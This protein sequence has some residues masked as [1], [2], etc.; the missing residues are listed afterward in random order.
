MFILIFV[1]KQSIS[2]ILDSKTQDFLNLH[3]RLGQIPSIGSLALNLGEVEPKK[4]IQYADEHAHKPSSRVKT[5]GGLS[6]LLTLLRL[7]P[8]MQSQVTAPQKEVSSSI[9]RVVASLLRNLEYWE[10]SH[11]LSHFAPQLYLSYVYKKEI[12]LIITWTENNFEA[13]EQPKEDGRIQLT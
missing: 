9:L 10:I 7:K 5:Q 8:L 2:S 13:S 1:Y 3:I 11:I 4:E 6:S 12:S